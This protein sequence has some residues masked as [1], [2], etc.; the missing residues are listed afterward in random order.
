MLPKRTAPALAALL[1]LSCA[2]KK[3]EPPQIS[4]S[5]AWSRATVAGQSSAAAYLTVTNTGDG[6]ERLLQVSTP[7]GRP[8]LHS[9]TMDNGVMRM[10]PLASLDIPAHSTVDLKPGGAHIMIMGVKQPLAAGS[11]FPLT[12]KFD[13]SGERTVTVAVRPATSTGGGM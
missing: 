11:S 13:R 6:D 5:G 1:L 2:S 4:I 7:I 3:S 8:S 10:R 12:L 9:T